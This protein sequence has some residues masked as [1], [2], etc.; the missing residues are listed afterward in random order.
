MNRKLE[1]YKHLCN[2]ERIV[3]KDDNPKSK[4]RIVLLNT[5][6]AKYWKVKIDGEVYKKGSPNE[7]CDYY[8]EHSEKHNE[9]FIELKGTHIDKAYSQLKTSICE[10]SEIFRL[11]KKNV[12]TVLRAIIVPMKYPQNGTD[13]QKYRRQFK[14]DFKCGRL[15]IC[16]SGHLYDLDKDKVI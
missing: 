15:D 12:E 16:N 10:F 3:I 7:R 13:A 11:H 14:N 2:D 1:P 4:S 8:V 9:Y 5:S 6:R